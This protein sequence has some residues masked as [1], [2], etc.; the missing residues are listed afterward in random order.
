[1]SVIF[2]RNYKKPQEIKREI[3]RKPLAAQQF[4]AVHKKM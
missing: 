1:L 3:S 4:A 2:I